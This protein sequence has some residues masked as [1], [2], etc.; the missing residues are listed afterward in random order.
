MF[1]SSHQPSRRG[2]GRTVLRWAAIVL[3]GLLL[4][5]VLTAGGL[6]LYAS[7]QLEEIDLPEL[8]PSGDGDAEGDQGDGDGGIQ[9]TLNVLVVGN[10][11]REGLTE[12]Q[13]QALGTTDEGTRLTDT[14][15]VVQ[16]SPVRDQAVVVAFPRDLRVPMPGAGDVK[17]NSVVARAEGDPGAL[18]EVVQGFTGLDLDHYVEINMAG[19]LELADVLGGVEV[20]L[21]E[22]L[23]DVYAGVDLSE[24]CQAL[25][26]TEALGFVRSRRTTTDQFGAGDFGRI[27]KQQYYLQQAMDKATQLGVL[28]NPV[29]VKNLIDAVA[30][31]VTTDRELGLLD[32]YRIANT[33]KGVNADDVVMR[34]VP[35]TI[36]QIDGQSFVVHEPGP[37]TD[38]F[39]A[40]RTGGEL[41]E[42]GLDAPDELQPE[43]VRVLIV[44][45]VGIEGLAG[46]VQSFLEQRDFDVIDAVN[47][48][49]L[50]PEDDF[51]TGLERLTIRHTEPGLARAELLVDRLGDLPVDLEQVEELPEDADVVLVVGSAWD[52]R[53]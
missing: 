48:S 22:P 11:T 47:P 45:G 20:C 6:W 38:L 36:Q 31:A 35:G 25:D 43:D 26:S 53:A 40:M 39:A 27:A 32:M 34:T 23:V 51:D 2:S 13:L 30:S 12:E 19:F 37:T 16:I 14:I 44:N 8:L 3:G 18:V 46:D 49:D 28:L 42:T 41:G 17:I 10:D 4:L 7:S 5:G 1:I 33:L 15:M 9:E 50:D 24:G 21:D 29:K 52:D